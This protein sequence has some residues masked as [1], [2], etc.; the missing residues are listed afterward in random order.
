MEC[1]DALV[2]KRQILTDM[3][4]ELRKSGH[5]LSR[6]LLFISLPGL[7]VP[8][9]GLFLLQHL[10]QWGRLAKIFFF[11]FIAEKK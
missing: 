3:L 10:A 4:G 8:K 1:E 5:W 2:R 11:H 6:S 7:E 9:G